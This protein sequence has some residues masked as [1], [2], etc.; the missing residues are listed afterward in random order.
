M[1]V[2]EPELLDPLG[3]LPR[4]AFHRPTQA[5]LALTLTLTL[6]RILTLTLTLTFQPPPVGEEGEEGEE[7]GRRQ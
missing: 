2:G 3:L 7:G 6:I 1:M 5:T 4:Y